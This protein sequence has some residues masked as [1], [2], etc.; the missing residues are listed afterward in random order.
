MADFHIRAGNRLP[1]IECDLFEADKPADLTTVTLV[2]LRYKPKTGGAVIVKTGEI[3]TASPGKVRYQWAAGDTNTAGVYL[4]A[5]RVTY[6]GGRSADY[7]NQG[8]FHIAIT[9]D[10]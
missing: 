5:W 1:A 10:L 9:N 6:S 4:A 3:V 8:G 7:P 2:E